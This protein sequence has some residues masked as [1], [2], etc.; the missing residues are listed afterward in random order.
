LVTSRKDTALDVLP[1]LFF[2]FHSCKIKSFFKALRFVAFGISPKFADAFA[3]QGWNHALPQEDF[4]ALFPRSCQKPVA[5]DRCHH[6]AFCY[7]NHFHRMRLSRF[8]DRPQASGSTDSGSGSSG[9]RF[10]FCAVG[11]KLWVNYVGFKLWVN[12]YDHYTACARF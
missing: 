7:A 1:C 9:F 5:T 10:K 3:A 12:Y 8:A 4:N 6:S 11:F 2:F